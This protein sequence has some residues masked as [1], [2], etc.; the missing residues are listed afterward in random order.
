MDRERPTVVSITAPSGTQNGDFDVT[1]TF[2]EPVN[3]FEPSE[4]TVTTGTGATAPS[5]WSSGSDGPMTY[6]GTI[7][8]SGVSSSEDSVDV[9]ISVPSRAAEDAAGNGNSVSSSSVDKTVT[10]DKKKP[11]PTIAAVSGTQSV[12][13]TI[14]INFDENVSNFRLSGISLTTQSGDAAGTVSNIGSPDNDAYTADDQIQ[15]HRDLADIG[16]SGCCRRLRQAMRV[17]FQGI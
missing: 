9:T 12:R 17:S 10:V 1:I 3:N 7:N 5:S 2:S 15:W 14:M 4:L 11:T 16:V 6:T 13:F 8:T